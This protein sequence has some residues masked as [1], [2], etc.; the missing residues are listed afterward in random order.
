M[1]E[2]HALC[3]VGLSGPRSPV[4]RRRNPYDE[5]RACRAVLAHI[6]CLRTPDQAYDGSL[7]PRSNITRAARVSLQADPPAH[8]PGRSLTYY[9]DTGILFKEMEPPLMRSCGRD[10]Q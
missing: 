10:P 3:L 1:I 9:N 8:N 4:N 6:A 7:P 2:V 5:P